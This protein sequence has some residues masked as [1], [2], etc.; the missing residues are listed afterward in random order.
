MNTLITKVSHKNVIFI[1]V[2]VGRK[3]PDNITSLFLGNEQ[4]DLHDEIAET[5]N[6][7]S[8]PIRLVEKILPKPDQQHV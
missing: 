3:I 5:N 6:F 7:Q 1:N 2:N 8:I 4:N